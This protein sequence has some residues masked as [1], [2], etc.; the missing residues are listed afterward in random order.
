MDHPPPSKHGPLAILV[1]VLH[2]RVGRLR[3]G[4]RLLARRGGL[5]RRPVRTLLLHHFLHL[6]QSGR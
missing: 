4:R 3:R 1:A 2:L 6:G 5:R